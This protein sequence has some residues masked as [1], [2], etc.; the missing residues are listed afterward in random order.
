MSTTKTTYAVAGITVLHIPSVRPDDPCANYD[1]LE[2]SIMMLSKGHKKHPDNRPFPVNTIFERDVEVRI[3]DGTILR[4]DV[5][6]PDYSDDQKVPAI[7][8]FSP[9]GKSG[10][11]S[12]NL[13]IICGRAGVPQHRLSGF[14]S[15]EAFDPAEWVQHG[16]AIVNV[17]ARGILG[18]QGSHRW[19]GVAEGQDGFDAIEYIAQLQWCDGHVALAGNSWLAS[20]QWFIA[21]ERPPH[22]TCI[23]PLEGLSDVYRESLC[24]GGVPYLPFWEFLGFNLWSDEE[25]EDVIS[26]IKTYPLM[27]EYWEDKRAK[28]HL[29]DVP[30]YVLTSMSTGLH[31]VGSTRCYEDIP[32]EKKWLRMNPTQEWHDLYQEDTIAD[33]K[34][35]LDHYMKGV[36]N[37]WE[38][39]PR[40]RISVIRYNQPSIKNI[41]FNAW[42]IPETDLQTLWLSSKG[43]MAASRP[44]I[45]AADVSYQS[46]AVA[47]QTDAD[48]E[49]A[50]FRYTFIQTTTLIGPS[51]AILY[52]SCPD[53]DDMDVFVILRKADRQGNVLRNINIPIRDLVGVQNESEVD[54]INSLQYVGPSGILRASHRTLDENLSK[55]HWPAHD[56][57]SEK[58]LVSS[59]VVKLEIGL[60]PAAI[61]FEQG[62]TL[63]LRVAGHQMTLAEFEPLRGKFETSNVG[64]HH[65]HFGGEYNS[66]ITIPV[67]Q[68]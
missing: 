6:R 15:F 4:A 32:H 16:Y 62:E 7:I 17:N 53:H 24:R 57:T 45:K 1:G 23:L 39:T 66:H 59:Q 36:D 47:L 41:P 5:F 63:I 28:A 9:Y 30:A 25:R 12:F 3:R 43:D 52:M 49:F 8:S 29:I 56:H 34:R 19:H 51:R 14:E 50:E 20:T 61:Q 31:T 2:P 68:V 13:N 64:R 11:G 60:W 26:M 67:V 33:L 44:A 65:V 55:P 18:S 48:T 46:D 22:L 27:N 40:A 35:F 42:P 37:D 21:A 58:K 10:T 38:Q 54:L